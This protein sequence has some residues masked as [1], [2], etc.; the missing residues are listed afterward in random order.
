MLFSHLSRN[1]I[2]KLLEEDGLARNALY[3]NSL[4]KK[5]VEC[6]LYVKTP[7]ALT[8]LP[9]FFGVFEALNA[10]KEF[11]SFIREFEGES[12]EAN[13]QRPLFSFPLPF[14]IALSGERLALNLLQRSSSIS[15]YTRK[16]LEKM[17]GSNIALL[18]TRKTT[19]GL[20][21]LEK[22]AVAKAGGLNHRFD[23]EDMWMVKDNHKNFHGGVRPAVEFFRSLGG[24]YTPL[25]VEVHNLNEL[26]ECCELEVGH[27]MLDN[28]SPEDVKRAVKEK[29]KNMTIEISGGI[30][31]DNIDQYLIEGVDAISIGSLTYSA[32][33]VDLSFKFGH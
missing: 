5:E 31:L 1:W 2:L 17:R 4:P 15:T 10:E 30:H 23:Q 16:F 14:C 32:P 8:G 13:T 12:L 20:R 26:A 11:D 27:V 3:L 18:D 29:P 33:A 7:M 22:Y 28:F 9:Y 19:P 24:F 21:S 25:I 6:S